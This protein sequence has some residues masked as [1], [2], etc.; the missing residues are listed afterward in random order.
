MSKQGD[1]IKEVESQTARDN[2]REA[3]AAQ[4][5]REKERS[6]EPEHRAEHIVAI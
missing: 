3:A 5:R 1:T 2:E 6:P 4:Q